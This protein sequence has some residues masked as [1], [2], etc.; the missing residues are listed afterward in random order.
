MVSALINTPSARLCLFIKLRF[1]AFW[2]LKDDWSRFQAAS[3]TLMKKK[4]KETQMWKK[5]EGWSDDARAK[6]TFRDIVTVQQTGVRVN[7]IL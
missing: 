3:C 2:G 4:H 5:T 7:V 1:V 6:L